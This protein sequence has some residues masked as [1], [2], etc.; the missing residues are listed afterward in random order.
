MPVPTAWV[1]A[2]C[3][4]E[5]LWGQ[6]T[7]RGP[8]YVKA[9]NALSWPTP[10]ASSQ[11]VLPPPGGLTCLT[12]TAE[13]PLRLRGPRRKGA[14]LTQQV[15]VPASLQTT[16][17]EAGAG[18]PLGLLSCSVS[19]GSVRPAHAAPCRL[20]AVRGWDPGLGRGGAGPRGGGASGPRP[21]AQGPFR[22]SV[23]SD[24]VISTACHPTENIVASAALENDKT[25]KLWKSDC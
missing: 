25:I 9:I 7:F 5:A 8:A 21:R 22:R 6:V 11:E 16:R 24:V 12:V 3:L 17:S 23:L 19:P 13:Q 10:G 14:L 4:T 1:D 15:A 18:R 2:Q 20:A